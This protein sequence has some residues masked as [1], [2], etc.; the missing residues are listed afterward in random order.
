M[1]K[2]LNSLIDRVAPLAASLQRRHPAP[3]PVSGPLG[4]FDIPEVPGI[5]LVTANKNRTENMLPAL[6][7][8]IERPEIDEIVIVDWDC[9]EPLRDVLAAKGISDPRLRVVRAAQ[10]EA[11]HGPRAF[12]TAMRLARYN[13]ILR[14]DGDIVV[15]PDFFA[16]NRL[17]RDSFVAGNYKIVEQHQV[18]INGTVFFHRADIIRIGGQNEYTIG[19]GWEDDD[20]YNRLMQ[21]RVKRIDLIPETVFHM[22]HDDTTRVPPPA[23]QSA[24]ALYMSWPRFTIRRNRILIEQMPA[25]DPSR[26]MQPFD[27]VVAPDGTETLVRTGPNPSEVSRVIADRVTNM[28]ILFFLARRKGE[29]VRELDDIHLSRLLDLPESEINRNMVKEIIA[30][31]NEAGGPFLSADIAKRFTP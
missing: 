3:A 14:I 19:Y 25:W 29:E 5:S 31:Q 18:H 1:T 13:K 9:D 8:W 28:S 27:L 11:W 6:K 20:F 7:S 12:N 2:F 10:D 17:P 22:P 21:A 15:K 30:K 4:G 23:N 16:R 24:R 26:P